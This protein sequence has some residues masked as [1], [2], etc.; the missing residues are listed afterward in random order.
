[1][2]SLVKAYIKKKYDKP[3]KVYLGLPH[4]L[5]RPV[6]GV[7]VLCKTSKA[8]TRMTKIF[9]ERKVT[10]IYHAI[11][12]ERPEVLSDKLVSYLKKDTKKNKSKVSKKPFVGGKISILNYSQ[13]A[14]IRDFNLLE[15]QLETGRPHQIRAQ[16]KQY[17]MPIYGDVK[18]H[19]Q[20]PLPDKSIALHAYSLSFQHPVKD[21]PVRVTAAYPKTEWWTVFA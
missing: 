4:R 10:K 11:T 7:L 5:D 6:S 2:V 21:E 13:I 18:Y 8:L 1:M 19:P 14:Q 16:L 9:K 12:D 20:K 15:V 17:K 3:G